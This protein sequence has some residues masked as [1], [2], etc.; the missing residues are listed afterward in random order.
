VQ[1][2]DE[3]ADQCP[4]REGLGQPLV[5]AGFQVELG[6]VGA[7]TIRG[8]SDRARISAMVAALDTASQS[9]LLETL[10]TTRS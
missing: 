10:H 5:R 3:G 7:T 6:V 9:D 1:R 8:A 4:W 2:C